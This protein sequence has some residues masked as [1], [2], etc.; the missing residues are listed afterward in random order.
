MVTA[1]QF[2]AILGLDGDKAPI[3]VDGEE[4]PIEAPAALEPGADPR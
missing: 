3:D 4:L 2:A 1:E